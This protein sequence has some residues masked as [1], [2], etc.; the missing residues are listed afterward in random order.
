MNLLINVPT[1]SGHNFKLTAIHSFLV[2]SAAGAREVV[3]SA[4]IP[5]THTP[6]PHSYALLPLLL[7]SLPT[8]SSLLS[9]HQIKFSKV[10]LWLSWAA[11]FLIDVCMRWLAIISS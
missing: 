9:T 7:C 1:R 5:L 2:M 6:S 10:I 4:L 3:A 11:R 8:C